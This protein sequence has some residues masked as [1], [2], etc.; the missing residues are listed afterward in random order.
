MFKE[1]M[2]IFDMWHNSTRPSK[3][4]LFLVKFKS[5]LVVV[6]QS[7]RFLFE[8]YVKSPLQ[9]SSVESLTTYLFLDLVNYLALGKILRSWVEVRNLCNK[10]IAPFLYFEVINIFRSWL[11]GDWM[12]VP[13]DTISLKPIR[14]EKHLVSAETFLKLFSFFLN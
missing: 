13:E 2:N 14:W 4:T 5:Y 9:T 1:S 8:V 10:F 11:V 3:K 7:Y 12:A 6:V